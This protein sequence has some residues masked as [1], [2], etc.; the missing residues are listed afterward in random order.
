MTE[1]NLREML[2][3]AKIRGE[4]LEKRA[5]WRNEKEG[6]TGVRVG[7]AKCTWPVTIQQLAFGG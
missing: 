1:T 2:E 6:F 5:E 7:T 3:M 4:S